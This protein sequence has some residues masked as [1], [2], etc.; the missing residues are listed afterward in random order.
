MLLN[1]H[2]SCWLI[3]DTMWHYCNVCGHCFVFPRENLP[4]KNEAP[5][6]LYFPV[7]GVSW[8]FQRTINEW[9]PMCSWS[10]SPCFPLVSLRALM[11][12]DVLYI[13]DLNKIIAIFKYILSNE[14]FIFDFR[15]GWSLFL[16]VH[17]RKKSALVLLMAWCWTDNKLLSKLFMDNCIN[18]VLHHS[19][20]I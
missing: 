20:L 1:K 19:S 5:L 4:Y 10:L 16:E 17:L 12:M 15:F 7:S 9:V 6:C 14:S 13:W 2:M 8:E 3:W 11:W 18:A